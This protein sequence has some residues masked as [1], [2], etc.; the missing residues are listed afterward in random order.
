MTPY[1]DIL[2]MA[3]LR[4]RLNIHSTRLQLI[5]MSTVQQKINFTRMISKSRQISNKL[6]NG[7]FF[8]VFFQRALAHFFQTCRTNFDE[9]STTKNN[10]KYLI[11]KPTWALKSF[12]NGN[13]F[14]K[15]MNGNSV[16]VLF[17]WLRVPYMKP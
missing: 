12:I 6:K 2:F 1:P 4:A 9:H 8:Y 3:F 10:F 16:Y 11:L 7:S 15:T 17:K 5:L 14:Y 13:S